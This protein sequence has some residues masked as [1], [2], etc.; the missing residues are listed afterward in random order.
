MA[1]PVP[2]DLSGILSLMTSELHI[3]AI[4]FINII[5]I[6]LIR[7]N[8]SFC[9]TYHRKFAIKGHYF[10][11]GGVTAVEANAFLW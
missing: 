4:I 8:I 2:L 6:F 10:F 3:E 9:Y 7:T 5:E 1:T 11:L